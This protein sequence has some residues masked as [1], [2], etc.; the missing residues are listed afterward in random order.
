MHH[1]LPPRLILPHIAFLLSLSSAV[2]L[3]SQPTMMMPI[4]PLHPTQC[5]EKLRRTEPYTNKVT[6]RRP[7]GKLDLDVEA[8]RQRQKDVEASG[9]LSGSLYVPPGPHRFQTEHPG[10]GENGGAVHFA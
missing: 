10:L 2:S 1:D 3:S 8:I 6:N 9:G 4:P 7:N 5:G